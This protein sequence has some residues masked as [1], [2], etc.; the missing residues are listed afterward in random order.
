M[1][2]KLGDRV[3]RPFLMDTIQ[4]WPLSAAMTATLFVAPLTIARVLIQVSALAPCLLLLQNAGPR[5]MRWA[6]VVT[7]LCELH[8]RG[9]SSED[10]FIMISGVRYL[11]RVPCKAS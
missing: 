9:L 8:H 11:Q 4:F 7:H 5:G 6:T 2:Q 10:A 1:L 3:M